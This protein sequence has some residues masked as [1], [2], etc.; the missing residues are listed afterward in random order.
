MILTSTGWGP[1]ILSVQTGVEDLW[2]ELRAWV[3]DTSI[4][5][6]DKLVGRWCDEESAEAECC[7]CP[8]AIL[9]WCFCCTVNTTFVDAG[10]MFL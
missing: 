8:D 6:V 3:G 10:M 4:E 9:V 1:V 2:S 5:L 7:F